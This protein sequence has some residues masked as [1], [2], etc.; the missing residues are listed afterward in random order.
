MD[1][2]SPIPYNYSNSILN[3][4]NTQLKTY[5]NHLESVIVGRDKIISSLNLQSNTLVIIDEQIKKDAKIKE[6]MEENASLCN[7]NADLLKQIKYLNDDVK[8]A[9]ND[10]RQCIDTF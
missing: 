3:M 2:K 8:R 5:I 6:L 7:E 10:V 4:N 9:K 1:N